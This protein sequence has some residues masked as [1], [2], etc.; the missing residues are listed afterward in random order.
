MLTRSTR[1]I[2]HLKETFSL[3]KDH[4]MKILTSPFFYFYEKYKHLIVSVMNEVFLFDIFI[5]V[6]SYKKCQIR[7]MHYV[8]TSTILFLATCLWYSL[9]IKASFLDEKSANCLIRVLEFLISLHLFETVI[10]WRKV[11]LIPNWK[12]V[13]SDV[14][15]VK[16]FFL[17][18]L[19]PTPQ[20]KICSNFILIFQNNY[21]I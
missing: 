11:V 8:I 19:P 13:I 18:R 10:S 16:L 6:K 17:L 20:K 14:K 7:E 12:H 1:G 21:D 9:L 4:F 15:K 3:H 2:W 5:L